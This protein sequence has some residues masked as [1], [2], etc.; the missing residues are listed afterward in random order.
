MFWI[1]KS[2]Y[3]ALANELAECKAKLENERNRYASLVEK[4]KK[5]SN[6]IFKLSDRLKLTD[7]ALEERIKQCS[8]LQEELSKE[9]HIVKNLTDNY[10][11]YT[12]YSDELFSELYKLDEEMALS[13]AKCH[14]MN[15]NIP[16]DNNIKT[17]ENEA[18]KQ[19]FKAKK[20]NK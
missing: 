5:D 14:D 19:P 18:L 3:N 2:K 12:A 20:K 15:S 7:T 4:Y 8:S 6:E 1:R 16:F 10:A 9:I 17:K 13:I 11:K